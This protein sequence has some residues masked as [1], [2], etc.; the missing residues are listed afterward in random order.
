MRSID[1]VE[2]EAKKSLPEWMMSYYATGTGDEQTLEENKAAYKRFLFKP[3]IMCAD[4]ATD[5]ST[6]VLGRRVRIPIGVSPTALQG[7]AH[8][9]AEMATAE[10]AERCGTVMIMSSWSQVRIED[11]A[12]SAPNGNLW[13]QTYLNKDRRNTQNIVERAEKAGFNAIVVTVDS[14]CVGIRKKKG[15][16]G[17][18]QFIKTLK[19]NV[20]EKG[21]VNYEGAVD[22]IAKARASGDVKLFKYVWDQSLSYPKW[23]YVEWLK[24]VTTLPLIMKGI[25]TVENAREAVAVGAKAVIVSNHGG[26]QLDGLPSTIEVLPEIVDA[27]RGSGVEVYVDGGI[28]NGSDVLKALALGAQFVFCGRPAV[29]GLGT[30][31]A[32]G[33]A[34][35]LQILENELKVTMVL[36]GCTKLTDIDR[37]LVIHESQLKCKL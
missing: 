17:G 18:D 24:T 13:M 7:G 16:Q 15:Y 10:G 3:R 12:K 34:E 30:N 26:R 20:A 35:V 8:P 14:P 37:S 5:I 19:G 29:W 32:D 31:G 11:V 33:V 1:D 9:R 28:R 4:K 21:F 27:L 25:M 36:C 23:E 6:S 22:D 2:E